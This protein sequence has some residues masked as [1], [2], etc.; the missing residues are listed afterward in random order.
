MKKALFLSLFALLFTSLRAQDI[1]IKNNGDEIKSKVIE[2]ND[3][4]IKYKTFENLDG[5]LYTMKKSEVFMIRYQNGGKDVFTRNQQEYPTNY[6]NQQ[7]YYMSGSNSNVGLLSYTRFDEVTMDGKSLTK[8][9][10]ENMFRKSCPTS[11][12]LFNSGYA[13]RKTGSILLCIG[14]PLLAA[15]IPLYIVDDDL[16][17]FASACDIVGTTLFFTSIGLKSAG[18]ARIVNSYKEY[19]NQVSRGSNA[20]SLNFGV[21]STGG[22]GVSLRF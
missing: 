19:N 9:E 12:E 15:S 16:Y 11:L 5:P 10:L 22:I 13:K 1:I 20:V 14:L 6:N 7:G 8:E 2:I 17:I 4:E 18:K 21:S 3:N